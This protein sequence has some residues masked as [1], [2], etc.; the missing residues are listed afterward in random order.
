MAALKK[1]KLMSD[2]GATIDGIDGDIVDFAL[3]NDFLGVDRILANDPKQ[4]NAQRDESG[5]SALMAAS[6]R[7]MERM[8]RH[9]LSKEGVDT[10]IT[11]NFGKDALD[12]GRIFPSVVKSIMQHR[13][14]D[15]RWSE[16]NIH[17]V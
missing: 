6:G 2:F 15:L 13:N 17:P 10:S 1:I 14:P 9:L 12:H 16:P 7:G 4:I 11:D 8:V 5:V 3:R